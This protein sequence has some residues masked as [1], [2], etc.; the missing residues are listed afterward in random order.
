MKD[1]EINSRD[2]YIDVIKGIGIISI[3]VG[4]A[5]WDIDLFGHTYHVG[6]FV[7]LYHLAIF[8]FCSG[9][10]YKD[11][12]KQYWGF[13]AKKLSGLYKPFI[14]YTFIY[15]IMRNF[16]VDIGIIDG[17]KF[18][19]GDFLIALTN[20][21]TFNGMAELLSAFWFLPVLFF[22]ICIFAA[23]LLI[24]DGVPYL[25]LRGIIRIIV[26]IFF[27]IIGL[28]AIENHL[29]LLYNMQIAYLMEPVIALGYYFARYK[30]RIQKY[31]NIIGLILSIGLLVWVV[32]SEIGII[33]LIQFSIINVWAFYPVTLCGIYFCLCLGKMICKNIK[34]A[35]VFSLLGRRSFD[36]M[37]MHFLA[38]KA[39]DFVVCH[40]LGKMDVLSM[41]PHSFNEIWAIYYFA[42]IVFPI[43]VSSFFVR[44]KKI[45]SDIIWEGKKD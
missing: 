28:Y 5:S 34:I 25:K 16:F 11:S 7:Y 44:M 38:F 8:F 6:V 23:I 24:T 19:K 37:A 26:F 20:M 40:L 27:G 3:V 41:F 31:I 36:I 29:G 1:V 33:E 2:S 32:E 42:G 17:V 10:L 39:V 22:A 15:L 4:H 35:K 18:D 9:Y 13:V 43:I 12:V 30:D 14:M 21:F 45:L